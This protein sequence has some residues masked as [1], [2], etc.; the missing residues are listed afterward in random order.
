MSKEFPRLTAPSSSDRILNP[1][2]MNT[3]GAGYS[4]EIGFFESVPSQRILM[5]SFSI[6]TKP[7]VEL[8]KITTFT[9]R[10]C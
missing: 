9:G 1:N 4:S 3:G 10:S 2:G 7:R 8:L 5:P 6:A